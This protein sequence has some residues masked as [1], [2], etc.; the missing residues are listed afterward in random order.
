MEKIIIMIEMHSIADWDCE[1]GIDIKKN[2]KSES[3]LSIKI[4]QP[5]FKLWVFSL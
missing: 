1:C 2:P 4:I 3:E 5:L